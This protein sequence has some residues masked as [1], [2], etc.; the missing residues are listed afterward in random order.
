MTTLREF[1]MECSQ[2]G[3][4]QRAISFAP[5]IGP[6]LWAVPVEWS[7]RLKKSAGYFHSS[8]LGITLHPDLKRQGRSAVV[9]TFLHETAHAMQWLRYR[10]V[11]HGESW[12]EAMHQL[13]QKPQRCHSMKL[14]SASRA[15]AASAEELDL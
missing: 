14:R 12:W 9:E 15:T 8:P 6:A 10:E 3:T 4:I 13:G 5:L 11:T 2:Q 1:A 7:L